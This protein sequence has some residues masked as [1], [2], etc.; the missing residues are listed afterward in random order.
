MQRLLPTPV[1]NHAGN[2]TKSPAYT[3]Y[4]GVYSLF[5]VNL[6]GSIFYTAT[7]SD[8]AIIISNVKTHPGN[9]FGITSY[10]IREQL[11]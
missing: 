6:D 11:P 1:L 7:P 10:I 4:V 9:T 5:D 8:H 3:G 2:T